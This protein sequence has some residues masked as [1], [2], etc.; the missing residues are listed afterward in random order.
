[1]VGDNHLAAIFTTFP[2]KKECGYDN[3]LLGMS[4]MKIEA[5][6]NASKRHELI[7]FDLSVYGE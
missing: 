6:M 4:P 7:S 2:S 5:S 3:V 1:M